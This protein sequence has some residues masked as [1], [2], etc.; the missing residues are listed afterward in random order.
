[1]RDGN[2]VLAL[3]SEHSRGRLDNSAAILLRLFLR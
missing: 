1:V 2:T 3:Q